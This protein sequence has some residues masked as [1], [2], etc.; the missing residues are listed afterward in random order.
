MPTLGAW[1]HNSGNCAGPTARD[2]SPSIAADAR[3]ARFPPADLSKSHVGTL[4]CVCASRDAILPEGL[5]SSGDTTWTSSSRA[6]NLS[7]YSR[8][9]WPCL[10]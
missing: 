5:K 1:N 4:A 3:W 8:P 6:Q 9:K 10:G 7:S 2:G